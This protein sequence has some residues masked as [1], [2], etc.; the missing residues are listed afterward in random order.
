MVIYTYVA[1]ASHVDLVSNKLDD[2]PTRY[3]GNGNLKN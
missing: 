2:T 3:I 1:I